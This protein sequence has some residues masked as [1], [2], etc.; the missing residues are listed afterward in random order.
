MIVS[1]ECLKIIA[2]SDVSLVPPVA[3]RNAAKRGL[4]MR[5]AAPKS[6]K[7]GLSPKEAKS[8]G[9]DSGVS[10]A[11]QL[12]SGKALSRETIGKMVSFFARHAKN[13]SKGGPRAKIAS[14][15]WGGNPGKTWANKVWKKIK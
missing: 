13:I 12:M 4:E 10:R 1:R 3:V 7:G 6:Q 2:S 5:K 11:R 8:Q 14:L 9:I 15:L